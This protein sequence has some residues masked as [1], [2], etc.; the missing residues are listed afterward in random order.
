MTMRADVGIDNIITCTS[1]YLV[2]ACMH[3][4]RPCTLTLL[5]SNFTYYMKD[6]GFYEGL[7]DHPLI[8]SLCTLVRTTANH[9]CVFIVIIS[10]DC[11]HVYGT[12]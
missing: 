7:D 2:H 9:S 12:S 1:E 4:D 8:L 11:T 3:C 10:I 6:L 5:Q